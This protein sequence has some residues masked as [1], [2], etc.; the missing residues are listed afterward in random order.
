MK[1]P[2][3]ANSFTMSPDDTQRVNLGL[4]AGT[5]PEQRAAPP[6]KNLFGADQGGVPTQ[7]LAPLTPER[8]SFKQILPSTEEEM[9]DRGIRPYLLVEVSCHER[10]VKG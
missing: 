8:P 10:D 1:A 3:S 9:L 7:T 5:L 4:V 2:D 6:V